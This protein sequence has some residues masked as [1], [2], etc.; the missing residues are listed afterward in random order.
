MTK[1]PDDVLET[2][3]D[4]LK[5]DLHELEQLNG[6]VKQENDLLKEQAQADKIKFEE[7]TQKLKMK[8]KSN[9]DLKHRN[10]A[11][12][13]KILNLKSMLLMKKPRTALVSKRSKRRKVEDTAGISE[14]T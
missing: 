14:Q 11:L 10:R 9:K 1:I 12:K 7:V 4:T 5:R 6:N 2:L 8:K 13:N 3:I